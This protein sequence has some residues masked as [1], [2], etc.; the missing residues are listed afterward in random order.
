MEI[1]ISIETLAEQNTADIFRAVAPF[2]EQ[3]TLL[4]LV[5]VN[6]AIKSLVV[7]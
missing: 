5:E 2:Q 7:L 3:Y 1:G 6:Q 4:S